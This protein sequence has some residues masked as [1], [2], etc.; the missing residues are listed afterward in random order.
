MRRLYMQ[1]VPMAQTRR[2]QRWLQLLQP[3]KIEWW[4]T[5][6][7]PDVALRLHIRSL[8]PPVQQITIFA[9]SD[10]PEVRLQGVAVMTDMPT[11]LVGSD[12]H[13]V[14]RITLY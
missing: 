2:A 12:D 3:N 4:G 13:L 10:A 1:I 6:E 14:S 9:N 11:Q 8:C 5:C 7:A